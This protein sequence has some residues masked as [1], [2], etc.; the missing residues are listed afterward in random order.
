MVSDAGK[1]DL[2][3]LD[4][5]IHSKVRLGIMAALASAEEVDFNF[6]KE[7]LNLTDGNLSA[8]M[9][10][11]EEAGYIEVTKTFLQRKPKTLY[12]ITSLGQKAFEQYLEHLRLII[13]DNLLHWK[14][15]DSSISYA[16]CC[17]GLL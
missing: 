9:R 7:K 17:A 8:N 13:G 16:V 15:D 2:Q 3:Q 5:L 12:R 1:F 10:R 14:K 6:L 4:D 11:L